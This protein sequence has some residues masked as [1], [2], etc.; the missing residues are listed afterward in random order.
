MRL[1]WTSGT[2]YGELPYSPPGYPNTAERQRKAPQRPAPV[3]GNRDGVF[4]SRFRALPHARHRHPTPQG[5][6]SAPARMTLAPDPL[7]GATQPKPESRARLA[8]Q[9][10]KMLSS[11]VGR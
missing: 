2:P 7:V 3:A 9:T 1:N 11:I 5:I 6:A 10:G 4:P 8:P